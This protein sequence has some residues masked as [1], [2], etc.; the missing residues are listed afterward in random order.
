MVK[1]WESDGLQKELL[2][3]EPLGDKANPDQLTRE[4]DQPQAS[5]SAANELIPTRIPYHAID[6][7]Q[8]LEKIHKHPVDEM[9]THTYT[10]PD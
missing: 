9:H 8:Q 4:A 1:P 6:G 7:P 5:L 3:T 2:S 10:L